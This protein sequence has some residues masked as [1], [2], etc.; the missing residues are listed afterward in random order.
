MGLCHKGIL[1]IQ[2]ITRILLT[3]VQVVAMALSVSHIIV[4]L[5]IE[6][7]SP[8]TPYIMNALC[9][10][11]SSNLE[12]LRTLS[13]SFLVGAI[14]MVFACLL[15]AWCFATLGRLFTY[16]VALVQDHSLVTS[17]PYAYVRHPSYTGV[18]LM[19][20]SAALTYLFS[21]GSYVAECGIMLT[22][23][24]WLI[25]Y[26]AVCCVFSVFSLVNRGKVEDELMKKTFSDEWIQYSRRV[27]YSFVPY[28][29]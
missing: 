3:N 18:F 5:A 16:R 7:P 9:P 25:R 2:L 27:P 12:L 26:W 21:Y 24:R 29:M 28:L 8:Q 13:P 14:A 15:R 4:I 10:Y 11:P 20:S 17:G 19:L 6:F 22:P 23:W 1:I